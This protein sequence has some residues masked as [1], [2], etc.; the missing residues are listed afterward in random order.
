M[1]IFPITIIINVIRSVL[2]YLNIAKFIDDEIIKQMNIEDVVSVPMSKLMVDRSKTA[3][4][5]VLSKIS[6]IKL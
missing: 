5:L 1:K 3:Y 6:L 2:K 4:L